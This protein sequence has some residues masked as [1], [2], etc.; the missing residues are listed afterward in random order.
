[1]TIATLISESIH[2]GLAYSFR[3]IVH[4]HHV[5]NMIACRQTGSGELAES[6]TFR[7][8]ESRQRKRDT[9]TGL[10]I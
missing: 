7:S 4:Y 5:G 2:L 9:G 6:F 3:D 10:S 1:M 8:T